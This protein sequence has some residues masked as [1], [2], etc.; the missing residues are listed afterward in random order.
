VLVSTLYSD[1]DARL[2]PVAAHSVNAHLRKLEREGR[3]KRGAEDVWL[4]R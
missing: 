3:V 1:V 2:H 4:N